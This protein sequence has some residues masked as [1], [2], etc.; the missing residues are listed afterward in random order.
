MDWLDGEI[1]GGRDDDL[2]DTGG[3]WNWVNVVLIGVFVLLAVG[4]FSV[5]HWLRD[6]VF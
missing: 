2:P 1:G 5:L 6:L 4:M 3:S